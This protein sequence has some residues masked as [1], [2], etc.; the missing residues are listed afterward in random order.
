MDDA[1]K[2]FYENYVR[3]LPQCEECEITLSDSGETAA[4]ETVNGDII[5]DACCTKRCIKEI[6]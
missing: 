4:V 5:C 6:S 2:F 1:T 3:E